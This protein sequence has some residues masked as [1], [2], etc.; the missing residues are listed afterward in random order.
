MLREQRPGGHDDGIAVVKRVNTKAER[1]PFWKLPKRN[2]L[3]SGNSS[4]N[5][6][7]CFFSGERESPRRESVFPGLRPSLITEKPFPASL[8]RRER[9][10]G[11]GDS[12]E[13]TIAP[14]SRDGQLG[15][16]KKTDAAPV[17]LFVAFCGYGFHSRESPKPIHRQHQGN[18]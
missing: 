18:S 16:A 2:A 14:C 1:V 15:F 9:K 12:W 6:E 11:R 3:R 5:P 7:P 10:K 8:T 17:L 13:D 4:F